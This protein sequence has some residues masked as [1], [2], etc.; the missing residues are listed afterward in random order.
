MWQ[1]LIR[2]M[3]YRSVI[4]LEPICNISENRHNNPQTHLNRFN[5]FFSRNKKFDEFNK[6]DKINNEII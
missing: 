2:N 6:N 5:P 3:F 1:T 4:V